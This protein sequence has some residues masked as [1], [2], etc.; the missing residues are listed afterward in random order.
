MLTACAQSGSGPLREK[1]EERWLKKQQAKPVP[2]A[3]SQIHSK[4]EKPG[5]YTYTIHFGG[6]SRFYK[7]HVPLNYNPAVPARV[8]FALHGGAGDM[9]VQANDGY[10][11]Q[12]SQSDAKNY[13]VVFP[14]G[15]SELNSGKLATWNAGKCCGKARDHKSDDVG[16]IKEILRVI[17]LQLNVDANHV[18]AAG[19]S[20]GGMMAYRLAC[21]LPGTFKA[22]AAVAGTDNTVECRPQQPVSILHIHAKNDDH[23][24][25]EG[26]AGQN[27]FKDRS[28]VTEFTS[29]ANTISKWVAIEGCE[30]APKKVLQTKG[31]FC[32]RY[33]QCKNGSAVQLCVTEDGGHSWPGGGRKPRRGVMMASPSKALSANTVMWEFFESL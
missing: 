21:E 18:Y 6:I 31:A 28:Q 9:E 26:G 3:S 32:E 11:G 30:G 16:F 27:A 14:N 17:S 25:Y 1:I 19:M 29:V 8:L 5:D 4:I 33:T 15:Y 22:I 24:L 12:I 10:Y 20:N 7:I 13:I 23:V 2:E